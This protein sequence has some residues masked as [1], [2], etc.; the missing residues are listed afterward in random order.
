MHGSIRPF[1]GSVR[2]GAHFSAQ[3]WHVTLVG[4]FEG[5]DDAFQ[6]T[7]AKQI[8]DG[9]RIDSTLDWAPLAT[10]LAAIKRLFLI[11]RLRSASSGRSM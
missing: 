8:F 2:D 4:D 9:L 5:G 1:A 6:H 10:T 7:D 11:P 3:D